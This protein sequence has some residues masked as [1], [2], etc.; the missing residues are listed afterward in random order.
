MMIVMHFD[1]NGKLIAV[2]GICKAGEFENE[3]LEAF[4]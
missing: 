4:E 2:G 1:E 3:L